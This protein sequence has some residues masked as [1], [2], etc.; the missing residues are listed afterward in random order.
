MSAI[1][2]SAVLLGLVITASGGSLSTRM[3]ELNRELKRQSEYL[4]ESCINTALLDISQNT[5]YV[6]VAGGESIYIDNDTCTIQSIEYDME[7]PFTHTKNANIHAHA[8][9]RGTWTTLQVEVHIASSS[10]AHIPSLP[11]ITLIS[12]Q[13]L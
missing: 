1:I 12:R 3:N 4:A 5:S 7:D 10:I 9:F 11:L 2:I 8:E 13:E 6:P